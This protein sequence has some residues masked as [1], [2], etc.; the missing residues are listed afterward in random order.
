MRALARNPFG[1]DISQSLLIHGTIFALLIAGMSISSRNV[2]VHSD[3]PVEVMLPKRIIPQVT[4]RR[5]V[6]PKMEVAK[7]NEPT[8]IQSAAGAPD[9][10]GQ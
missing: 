9:F 4:P 3:I 1:Y 8:S 7:A 5:R 2:H 6:I 10:Y